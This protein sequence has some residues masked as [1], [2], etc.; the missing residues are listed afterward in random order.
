MEFQRNLR[1][2]EQV[3]RVVRKAKM[4]VG[5]L[6]RLLPNVGG[7]RASKRRVL[8]SVVHGILLYGAEVWIDGYRIQKYRQMLL[9]VQRNMLLRVCCAYRTVSGEALCVLAGVPPLDLLAEERLQEWKRR[10][11]ERVRESSL[12]PSITCKEKARKD[13]MQ[14]WCERWRQTEKAAWTRRLIPNLTEWV[15][16]GHGEVNHYTSQVLTGHGSFGAYLK[17][18]GKIECL[19]CWCCEE[20]VEEDAELAIFDCHR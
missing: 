7:P 13:L 3:K 6:G 1:V 18:I 2:A 15:G 19:V 4:V 9:G 11:N 14:A 17:R 12:A 8:C 10:K 20:E 5:A 16:R